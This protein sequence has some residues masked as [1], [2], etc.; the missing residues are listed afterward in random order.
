MTEDTVKCNRCESDTPESEVI[1]V[2]A[3]WLCGIC[4]DEV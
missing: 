4:Y 3:W 2:H 1:E